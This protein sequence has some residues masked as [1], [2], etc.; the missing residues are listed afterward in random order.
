MTA[1]RE[2][3]LAN[4]AKG[5]NNEKHGI[6]ALIPLSTDQWPEPLAAAYQERVVQLLKLPHIDAELDAGVVAQVA[7]WE[8]ILD[9]LY[10]WLLRQEMVNEKGKHQPIL[11]TLAGFENALSRFYERAGLS[12]ESRRRMGLT[13]QGVSWAKELSSDDD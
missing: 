1:P 13:A 5:N 2:V 7:R 9:K 6:Y 10:S 11:N 8:I 3:A 12:P 4:L